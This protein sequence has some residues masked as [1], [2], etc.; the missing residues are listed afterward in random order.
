MTSSKY[1]TQLQAGLGM[2]AETRALLDIWQPG[3]SV[4]A[5]F[6]EALRSG[7]FP[8]VA[9]RRLR[10]IVAECFAPRYLVNDA[11]PAHLLKSLV[12]H[13]ETLEF[14]QLLY[15][16][17]CRAN[18]ILAN[19][20]REVYWRAYE[21]GNEVISNDDAQ[22]FVIHAIQE[23]KTSTSWSESTI[24]RVAAYL[25]GCC[26]DFGLLE[27]SKRGSRR[28]LSYRIGLRV[29]CLLAY[30]LKFL[31][32]GDQ[33]LLTDPDWGLFGMSRSDTIEELKLLGLRGF[34]IVQ[35]AG[36]LVHISWKYD[37]YEELV[38]VIAKDKSR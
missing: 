5:L 18:A 34:L 29:A 22:R 12:S 26:A 8:Q 1:T 4:N 21:S 28:I 23:G 7:Q 17:T 3:M 19:F 16:H 11:R 2:V 20:V 25:T 27:R 9:A 13:L 10:N 6:E 15:L 33:R 38:D 14:L 36:D 24:R 32:R 37:N 35:S 31:G 30:D